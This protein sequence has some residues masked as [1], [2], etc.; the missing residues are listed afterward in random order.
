HILGLGPDGTAKTPKWAEEIS[1]V[2]AA[3][4][5][6]VARRWAG[7][8]TT[9]GSGMRGGFGGA[10][11]TVGGTDYARLLVSLLAMQGM[12]K[13]GRNMWTGTCG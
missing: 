6:A 7:T 12:G 4:I 2:P 5:K 13:P 3:D 11:R 9:G 10:C 8:V 1:G